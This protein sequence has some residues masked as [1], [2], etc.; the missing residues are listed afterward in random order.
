MVNKNSNNSR[1]VCQRKY[2]NT[3]HSIRGTLG[4]RFKIKRL[5]LFIVFVLRFLILTVTNTYE[6]PV[7]IK[8]NQLN[9]KH[10]VSQYEEYRQALNGF[11]D[12]ECET[13][14]QILEQTDG[15]AREVEKAKEEFQKELAED[16]ASYG[17]DFKHRIR[18]A[19]AR[20]LGQDGL[21]AYRKELTAICQYLNE[22]IQAS[23]LWEDA[24]WEDA[25]AARGMTGAQLK[26]LLEAGKAITAR[27]E[28]AQ[29]TAGY[30]LTLEMDYGDDG[31]WLPSYAPYMVYQV[32]GRWIWGD[33]VYIFSHMIRP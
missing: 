15:Y 24:A 4:I 3:E 7:K 6:R 1:Y 12:K 14:I 25:A 11:A 13:A 30:Q 2:K 22:Y 21:D 17:E 20:E 31:N 8:E 23:A 5:D 33:A 10:F 26:Q 18:I 16:K 9:S 32:D 19:E 27:L 28:N 29:I